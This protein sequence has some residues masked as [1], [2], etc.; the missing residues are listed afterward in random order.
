MK[1]TMNMRAPLRCT[2]LL[3]FLVAVGGALARA[4]EGKATVIRGEIEEARDRLPPDELLG[5]DIVHAFTFTLSGKNDVKESWVHSIRKGNGELHEFQRGD[6]ATT[7]G[8]VDNEHVVWHVLGEKGLQR[9]DVNK[10]F[11]GMMTIEVRGGNSCTIN[12]SYL[13]QKGYSDVV[14]KRGDNGQMAHFTLPR[15]MRAS[16]TIE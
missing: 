10:Q 4:E 13:K 6:V 5:I 9:I 1:A 2:A 8:G 7:M 3:M 12:M 16:C 11:I 14:M 15:L